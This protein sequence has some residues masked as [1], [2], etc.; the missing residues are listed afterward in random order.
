MDDSVEVG[1][2]T[3]QYTAHGESSKKEI[4]EF[5][6]ELRA[7]VASLDEA[8]AMIEAYSFPEFDSRLSWVEDKPAKEK[9]DNE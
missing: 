5:R 7:M 3:V 1:E 8:N 2:M 9:E 6:R 4:D